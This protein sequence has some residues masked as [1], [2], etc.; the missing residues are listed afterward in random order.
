M[1]QLAAIEKSVKDISISHDTTPTR[2]SPRN[3]LLIVSSYDS[4]SITIAAYEGDT[5]FG[6]QTLQAGD[7]AD[8][9]VA[10]VLGSNPTV[11]IRS[12]LSSLKDSLESH[13]TSTRVNEA[14]VSPS[15]PRHI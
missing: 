1:F 11:E 8:R 12:A 4:P 10:C 13:G 14:Y 3:E 6:T 5:S 2:S 9:T 7:A 15:A